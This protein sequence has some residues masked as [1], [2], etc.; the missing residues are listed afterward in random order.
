MNLAEK[1]GNYSRTADG[2]RFPRT[3]GRVFIPTGVAPLRDEG[4]WGTVRPLGS[5]LRPAKDPQTPCRRQGGSSMLAE[6]RDVEKLV[7]AAHMQIADNESNQ[8]VLVITQP[9]SVIG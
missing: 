6:C 9:C 1:K 7:L 4:G 8:V 2:H 3:G 5:Y